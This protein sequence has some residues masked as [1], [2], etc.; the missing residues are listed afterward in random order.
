MALEGSL[1]EFNLADIL[2]L[3]YFQ[4]KTGVL[5]ISGKSDKIRLLFH[6]GH[7]VSA[8]SQKRD[9]GGRLGRV[10]VSRGIITTETLESA[11]ARQ[12]ESGG[13]LGAILIM[14]GRATADQIKLVLISQIS[15]TVNQLFTWKEGRY[16]FTAQAVPVD[17]DIP[18][19]IDTQHILMEG[20]RQLD[21]WTQIGDKINV[22]TVFIPGDETGGELSEEESRIL[23][24][25]DGDNDVGT[26]AD[27]TGVDSFNVSMILLGL[28]HKNRIA[29]KEAPA[30]HV[31]EVRA[32]VPPPPMP[33]L[34]LILILILV[35]SILISTVITWRF[36][37][38]DMSMFKA[39]RQMDSMRTEIEV[40][41]HITGS[42]P[43]E[44]KESDPWGTPYIYTL[45]QQGYVLKSAGPDRTPDTADDIP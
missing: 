4:R 26:I 25:V 14:E 11:I 5:S 3:L 37:M 2:Q 23:A 7:I 19:S 33:H 17:K 13:R 16:D 27:L 39:V 22:D 28:L 12:K 1:K 31:E 6:E 36:G 38:L 15:E 10:L 34:G 9:V 29:K 32:Y 42:Y 35:F 20:L 8:E 44:V 41:R 21:E 43:S 40:S 24:F 30:P 45:D 18:I